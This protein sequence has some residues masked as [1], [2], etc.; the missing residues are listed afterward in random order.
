MIR[1]DEIDDEGLI[2]N[3]VIEH[4]LE[5]DLVV[6]DL[7]DLN[8]NVF[9]E[10]AVRHAV[11]K[12]IVHLI[13]AGQEIPF[14]VA[15]MRAVPYALD[16]PDLL[17]EAQEELS[18]KVK[19]I[20]DADWVAAPNPISAAREV[21]LLKESEQPEARAAGDLLGAVSEL[22]DEVRA[23]TRRV[24]PD[25]PPGRLPMRERVLADLLINDAASISDVAARLD[26]S[27]STIAGSLSVLYQEGRAKK[28]PDGRWAVV[29]TSLDELS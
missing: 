20:E 25:Q 12:P 29:T 22:R 4:L 1:A 7:T 9:Y 19:A 27:Q 2:T 15:N 23:L 26:V 16:D 6:A 28:M 10:V 3:Q 5:D 17:E 11:R 24:Y 8:P 18:R 13:T 21:S 14:D